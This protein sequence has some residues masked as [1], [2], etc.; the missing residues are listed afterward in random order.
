MMN[1][2]PRFASALLLFEPSWYPLAVRKLLC[3]P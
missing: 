2:L 3:L 1:L